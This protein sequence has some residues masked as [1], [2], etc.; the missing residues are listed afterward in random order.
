[1][2]LRNIGSVGHTHTWESL[3]PMNMS[4]A[5]VVTARLFLLS[6]NIQVMVSTIVTQGKNRVGIDKVVSE[7][8]AKEPRTE[9]GI[10][11][12]VH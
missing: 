10:T 2:D 4:G 12:G 1:M 5:D 3:P 7:V 6:I 8:L 9:T 11:F